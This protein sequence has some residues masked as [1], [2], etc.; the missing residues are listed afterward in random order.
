MESDKVMFFNLSKAGPCPCLTLSLVGR[1]AEAEFTEVSVWRDD[2]HNDFFSTQT[3]KYFAHDR[4]C[5]S[6]KMWDISLYL[7]E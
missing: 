6:G 2:R 7:V 4:R 1:E 3:L 5:F